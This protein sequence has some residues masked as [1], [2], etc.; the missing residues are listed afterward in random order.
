MDITRRLVFTGLALLACGG[1]ATPVHA[2]SLLVNGDFETGST[3]GWTAFPAT[4]P[5]MGT[6]FRVQTSGELCGD[7]RVLPCRPAHTGL[8]DMAF[9]GDMNLFD[10]QGLEDVLAQSV[11]T[12]PGQSYALNFWMAQD[13]PGLACCYN[14]FRV[15]WNGSPVLATRNLPDSNYINYQLSLVATGTVSTLA[16]G[17]MNLPGWNRLDDVTLT[18]VPEPAS[19]WL[20]VLGVSSVLALAERAKNSFI[21]R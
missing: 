18:E 11:A 8:Y 7:P 21:A 13:S 15:F 16:F 10:I 3:F 9:G 12:T 5:G 4:P 6:L 14:E 20:L 17:S 19:I 1:F 2:T